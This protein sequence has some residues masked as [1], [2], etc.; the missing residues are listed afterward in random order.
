ML[1]S[2]APSQLAKK[3]KS[4]S[5]EQPPAAISV[6]PTP[7]SSRIA[8]PRRSKAPPAK[9]D[10]PSHS[11]GQSKAAEASVATEKDVKS[12]PN[13]GGLAIEDCDS[14]K[15]HD[16]PTALVRPCEVKLDRIDAPPTPTAELPSVKECSVR[17]EGI[18]A[19]RLSRPCLVKLKRIRSSQEEVS[20]AMDREGAGLLVVNDEA[21]ADPDPL[22]GGILDE[23]AVIQG[24]KRG[25]EDEEEDEE[26]LIDSAQVEQ[27]APSFV[28]VD[29]SLIK[30]F[31]EYPTLAAHHHDELGS[32]YGG[33]LSSS[34]EEEEEAKGAKVVI[35]SRRAPSR[36]ALAA[37]RDEFGLPQHR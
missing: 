28:S 37:T 26:D 1:R 13:P 20:S 16:P 30:S 4:V 3:H 19:A 2:R 22:A 14:E 18:P 33:D 25:D 21:A 12:D 24:P 6:S 8:A 10:T 9:A 34:S 5:F 17:L 23:E 32:S 15:P 27:P 11:K 7:A 36:S 29:R 35:A 31:Y